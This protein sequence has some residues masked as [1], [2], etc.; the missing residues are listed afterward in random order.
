[1]TTLYYSLAKNCEYLN[2]IGLVPFYK[3]LNKRG[4]FVN[5]NCGYLL[6]YCLLSYPLKSLIKI[7]HI[8]SHK[9]VT[10]CLWCTL[11]SL[12]GP[13]LLVSSFFQQYQ[14]SIWVKGVNEG[15]VILASCEYYFIRLHENLL[16]HPC[17]N[18]SIII[19]S[20]YRI[21]LYKSSRICVCL[22]RNIQLAV[23]RI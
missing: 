19:L 11:A 23:E 8:N 3:C 13:H 22:P 6:I 1:M 12:Y 9:D 2:L 18:I 4:Y 17:N 21:S 16:E 7:K 14:G 20:S 10:I 15:S 5:H